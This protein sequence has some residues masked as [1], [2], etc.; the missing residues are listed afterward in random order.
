MSERSGTPSV[1]PPS[2]PVRREVPPADVAEF[3]RFCHH[4][5]PTGW[6]ELYDEMCSVAARREFHGWGHDQLAAHGI[7][8]ALPEMPRLAAWVRAVIPPVSEP[9]PEPLLGLAP[10]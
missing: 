8:F 2:A 9:A 10:A 7:T 5:R 3:I 6:P 1:R 4:R